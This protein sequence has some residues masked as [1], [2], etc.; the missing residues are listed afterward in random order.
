MRSNGYYIG[1]LRTDEW[2]EDQGMDGEGGYYK[3]H[4]YSQTACFNE[5]ESGARDERDETSSD[6][7]KRG[8]VIK[9]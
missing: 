7:S 5:E 3:R 8:Q 1:K 4:G 2:M 9:Q 6:G